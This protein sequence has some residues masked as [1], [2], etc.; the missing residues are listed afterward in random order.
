VRLARSLLPAMGRA[1]RPS[2][3]AAGN[4][5]ASELTAMRESARVLRWLRFLRMRA[6]CRAEVWIWHSFPVAGSRHVGTPP[7]ADLADDGF[8]RRRSGASSGH[9]PPADLGVAS[10]TART[11]LDSVFAKT[12][13]FR[14]P[15]VPP[16]AKG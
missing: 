13:V 9:R 15:Q 1:F 4:L 8:V 10:T 11:H 7:K 5:E 3:I 6:C 2:A 16:P 14:R 12:G